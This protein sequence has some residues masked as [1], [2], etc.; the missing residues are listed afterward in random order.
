MTALNRTKTNQTR[1]KK[2]ISISNKAETKD[3]IAPPPRTDDLYDLYDLFPLVHDILIDLSR[4]I[5]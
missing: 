4:Q 1:Q 5:D 2:N 3:R